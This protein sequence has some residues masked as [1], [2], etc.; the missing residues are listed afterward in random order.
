MTPY[1]AS[2]APLGLGDRVPIVLG[3]FAVF[4]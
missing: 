1:S 2:A 3:R 4:R